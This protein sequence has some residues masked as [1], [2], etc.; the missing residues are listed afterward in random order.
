MILTVFDGLN[1]SFDA[2]LV[3][4]IKRTSKPPIITM[5]NIYENQNK[6]EI[7]PHTS[8]IKI[9]CKKIIIL[10]DTGWLKNIKIRGIVNA[11]NIIK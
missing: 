2:T 8:L 4:Y 9:T 11:N 7:K 3:M 5:N 1:F 10:S 6:F